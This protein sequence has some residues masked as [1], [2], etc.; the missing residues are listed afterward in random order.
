MALDDPI[1][2]RAALTVWFMYAAGQVL[3]ALLRL[4]WKERK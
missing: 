3:A 4:W 1:T 2:W